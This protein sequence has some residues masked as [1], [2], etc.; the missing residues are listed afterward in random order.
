MFCFKSSYFTNSMMFYVLGRNSL[1]LI[2][3]LISKGAAV[4][5]NHPDWNRQSRGGTPLHV[6]A[7]LG[8]T[9]NALTLLENGAQPNI[10]DSTGQTALHIAAAH[11]LTGDCSL[12][13]ISNFYG[14][15]ITPT[16]RL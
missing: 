13:I 10:F 6:A 12:L 1:D 14:L 4:N 5:L 16:P 7:R 2:K 8:R 9:E 3:T 11:D 15:R